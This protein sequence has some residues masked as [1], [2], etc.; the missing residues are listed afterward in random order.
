MVPRAGSSS[1]P[2]A[3]VLEVCG[4]VLS[5]TSLSLKVG[6]VRAVRK[7]VRID[8][9]ARGQSMPVMPPVPALSTMVS[10]LGIE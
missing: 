8:Q 6:H 4:G 1:P 7:S 5:P 2:G 3:N 9:M 10:I